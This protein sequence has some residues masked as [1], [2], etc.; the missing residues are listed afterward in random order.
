MA[1]NLSNPGES[2]WRRKLSETER[3][4]LRTQ[5]ELALEAQLTDALARLPAAAAPSNFTA[6]VLDAIELEEKAGARGR[7]TWNWRLLFPRLAVATAV[8]IFI[9]I[10]VQ[11]HETRVQHQRL[12]KNLATLASA[13]PPSVD[14]LENLD[15]IQRM[16]QTGHADGEL[17]A[18]LQ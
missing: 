15:A 2:L 12:A 9:G 18:V 10:G 1:N 4:A 3:A 6:R 7:Q 14:A 11:R 16:S 8:L 5:P 17:L 13:Q